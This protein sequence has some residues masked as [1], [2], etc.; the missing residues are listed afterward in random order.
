MKIARLA[1]CCCLAH[2]P[3][4]DVPPPETQIAGAVLAAPDD[5]RAGATVLGWDATGKIV[6]LRPGTND[7]V[8]LADNPKVDGF[9]V[10]CYHK[11]LEPFMARGRELTAQGITE[12]KDRDGTRW[13]EIDA[14]KLAMPKETRTLAV[15]TGKAFD[16]ATGQVA[17][18]YTRW[19][20][21]VPHATGASTGLPT[22]AGARRAMAD[23]PWHRRRAHHDQP[24]APGRPAAVAPDAASLAG[25]RARRRGDDL[26]Q[27]REPLR[28]A[29]PGADS[30]SPPMP[31]N[32]YV[33]DG[34]AR[35]KRHRLFAEA[36]DLEHVGRRHLEDEVAAW[37]FSTLR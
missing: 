20:L 5:R 37:S 23:G 4:Q 29:R 21:Y 27:R 35:R 8:L 33:L 22:T 25:C 12:D 16:A 2:P 19:V 34:D 1:C 30:D 36:A 31:L 24:G 28:L 13:K 17:E 7:Q 18:G 26:D 9:N 3:A 15:T 14:G 10:A 32:V 11:D 6:T